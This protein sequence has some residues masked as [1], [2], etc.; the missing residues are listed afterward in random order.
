MASVGLQEIDCFVFNV[1]LRAVLECYLPCADKQA[2][3]SPE[4]PAWL[5]LWPVCHLQAA[6]PCWGCA[7]QG[8]AA[9]SSPEIIISS[10]L[11]LSSKGYV[12]NFNFFPFD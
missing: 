6:A 3:G 8:L 1:I 11:L 12:V 7:Q 2:G 10:K 5:L 4:E 9:L